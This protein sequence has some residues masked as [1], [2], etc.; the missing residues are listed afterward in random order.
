MEMDPVWCTVGE[1][2]EEETGLSSPS[3]DSDQANDQEERQRNAEVDGF[4]QSKIPYSKHPFGK[5]KKKAKRR[6]W[7]GDIPFSGSHRTNNSVQ[8]ALGNISHSYP[9]PSFHRKDAQVFHSQESTPFTTCSSIP[10]PLP[11]QKFTLSNLRFNIHSTTNSSSATHRLPLHQRLASRLPSLKT[12][13][14]PSSTSSS[15][16]PSALPSSFRS[17]SSSG[18]ESETNCTNNNSNKKKKQVL[19]KLENN[20]IVEPSSSYGEPQGIDSSAIFAPRSPPL[21]GDSYLNMAS[22]TKP[23]VYSSP[24]SAEYDSPPASLLA[25]VNALSAS[26][27]IRLN[28][29]PGDLAAAE[30]SPESLTDPAKTAEQERDIVATEGVDLKQSD[31]PGMREDKGEE[32]LRQTAPKNVPYPPQVR[33]RSAHIH[34][35]KA[36]DKSGSSSSLGSE[37]PALKHSKSSMCSTEGVFFFDE[38]IDRYQGSGPDDNDGVSRFDAIN[39]IVC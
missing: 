30:S 15:A 22:E 25:A 33:G 24:D 10:R 37:D 7:K 16:S 3:Q 26:D 9:L 21:R 20:V 19:L 28:R 17:R 11:V 36:G 38:E 6:K 8:Q 29:P 5:S 23:T 31:Q 13:S 34:N 12:T 18:Q 39:R 32:P 4:R 1:S 27:D 35:L 14:L 2:E